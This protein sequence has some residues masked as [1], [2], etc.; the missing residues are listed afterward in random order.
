MPNI[1][2]VAQAYGFQTYRIHNNE[3]LDRAL[4]EMMKDDEPLLCELMV[5][6]EET[7][8]PRVKAIVGENGKMTSGPLEM[9][10]PYV[11]L[12]V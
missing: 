9:M 4:Q 11:D 10:W 6:P 12:S 1:S 2:K 5:L 7:V 3:E 8:S